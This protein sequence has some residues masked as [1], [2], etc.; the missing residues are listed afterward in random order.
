MSSSFMNVLNRI[1]EVAR[2][3]LMTTLILAL[4]KAFGTEIW[5]HVIFVFTWADIALY[6]GY[7]LEEL[8]DKFI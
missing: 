7:S 6:S 8:L 5:K 3:G 2:S 1:D 4:T